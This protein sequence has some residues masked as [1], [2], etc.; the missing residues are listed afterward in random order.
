MRSSFRISV[1]LIATGVVGLALVGCGQSQSPSTPPAVPAPSN[2]PHSSSQG[3]S[4][5]G[6]NVT[7]QQAGQ[8]VT[9]S[10]GGQVINVEADRGKG[11]PSW[12]VE[13]RNSN[14]GRIEV[15]VAQDNGAIVEME[16]D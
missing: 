1:L 9:D 7:Q 2:Q 10:Y 3:Q 4:A 11:R 5:S 8:I 16:R 13:V 15:D 12:E 6:G 14:Q